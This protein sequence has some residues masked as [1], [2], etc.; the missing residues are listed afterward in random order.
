MIVF[1]NGCRAAPPAATVTPGPA[2]EAGLTTDVPAPASTPADGEDA[3]RLA[4]R[5]AGAAEPA[6]AAT[7]RLKPF[8][9]VVVLPEGP[10]VELTAWVCLEYG[11][12]E[13][14][15]C[16][17]G[18][19]EHESLVVPRARP[20]QIHA[21]LLMAGFEP[22]APGNWSYENEQY[23]F[24]PP[25]GTAL[26]V[27]VRYDVAGGGIVEEPIRAWI[28]DHHG[29]HEFPDEP[30]IFAGSIIAP[31]PD[32]MEEE[33]EHYVA[34]VTGSIIGLVTFGDEVI[35]FSRVLAD[36]AAVQPPEWEVDVEHIPPVGTE[37]TIIL[38]RRIS[39]R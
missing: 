21:A 11:W 3:D 37:V 33:G 8:P 39:D 17:P 15:A 30:W 38:R 29:R 16:A 9:G 6:E 2:D 18:T 23:T 1:L 20:S 13:Q 36:Q 31:N 32:W 10:A 35:G 5:R 28:R 27:F 19:R 34:D 7:K 25:A 26:D 4:E 12:L 24:T 14:I 22:G